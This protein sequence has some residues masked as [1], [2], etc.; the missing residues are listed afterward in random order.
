M[1][2]RMWRRGAGQEI[3]EVICL[4]DAIEVR[5]HLRSRSGFLLVARHFVGPD[6]PADRRARRRRASPSR[7]QGLVRSSSREQRVLD[8]V[9]IQA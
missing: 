1:R 8:A 5:G 7:P 3:S 6:G 4:D 9:R 2:I